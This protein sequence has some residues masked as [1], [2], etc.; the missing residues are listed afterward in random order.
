MHWSLCDIACF[1]KLAYRPGSISG[2]QSESLKKK[3]GIYYRWLFFRESVEGWC[4]IW[5]SECRAGEAHSKVNTHLYLNDP[6]RNT[7]LSTPAFIK[8]L[9]PTSNYRTAGRPAGQ[10]QQRPLGGCSFPRNTLISVTSDPGTSPQAHTH[11]CLNPKHSFAQCSIL[12]LYT[13][14][15]WINKTLTQTRQTRHIPG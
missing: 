3:E 8:V 13:H 9:R 4:Y 1:P 14:K 6:N 10:T 2:N 12:S 7:H 15:V 5:S 11:S